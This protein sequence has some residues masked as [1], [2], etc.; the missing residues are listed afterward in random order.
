MI[1]YV[2]VPAVEV[3]GSYYL[4]SKPRE[5]AENVS[6]WQSIIQNWASQMS[7][8]LNKIT[9]IRLDACTRKLL[10]SLGKAK[11]LSLKEQKRSTGSKIIEV[12]NSFFRYDIK[13]VLKFILKIII[14][15]RTF[16]SL[17]QFL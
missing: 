7:S 14:K 9:Q 11:F 1:E 2:V 17:F 15:I 13:V 5:I 10:C 8:I 3:H 12:F 6:R 4:G 16:E